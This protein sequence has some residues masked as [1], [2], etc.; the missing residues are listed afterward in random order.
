LREEFEPGIGW[1]SGVEGASLGHGMSQPWTDA[2][3]QLLGTK[4]DADVGRL[5]GRPGK[6]VWAKRQ[7]LGIVDAPSLVRS[8]TDDEDKVVLS[9]PVAEAA[10]ALNRTIVAVKIR[11]IKLLRKLGPEKPLQ[12]LTLEDARLRIAVPK[13]DSNEQEE[14]CRLLG[15]PYVPPLIAIGGWLKCELRGELQV[16]GYTNA[17]I[18]WPVAVGHA[19]QRIV[20]GDLV[21]ALKTESLAAV[22]FH[23]GICHSLVSEYRHR[24]GIERFTPG[25][26]RLFRR[27][28]D[29]ARTAEARAKISRHHE[30]RGDAMTPEAR[31]KLREI[32]RRPKS[33]KW[34]QKMG[35]RWRRRFTLLGRPA[36]WTED[37]LN[38]IGTRPDR[39]VAKLLN[40][41]LS[42]VKGK[43]FQLLRQKRAQCESATVAASPARQTAAV[44]SK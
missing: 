32:Q 7:A 44:S 21:R 18:P 9:H 3:I 1:T 15:G 30:G 25:S 13:Y 4:P 12:V 40:R 38:L 20:C 11:R 6:A 14:K 29:L 8:W 41:S 2:E 23:F 35:E 42:S 31:E 43:K 36:R 17:L 19:Q 39:E 27:T 28:I 26:M 33:E 5:I 24:L 22:S 16:G 10:Q 34:K 37:E